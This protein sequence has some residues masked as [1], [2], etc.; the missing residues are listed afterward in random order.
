MDSLVKLIQ[1]LGT[2]DW[3][4]RCRPA[5]DELYSAKGGRYPDRAQKV[6]AQRVPEFK[7]D[8]GVAFGAL[9][10]PFNPDS[11]PYGGMS[12]VVF[13]MPDVPMRSANLT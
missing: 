8:T 12:F 11:G 9:I 5:F 1:T 7:G 6:A 10:H 13:P 4:T 2:A 3:Q